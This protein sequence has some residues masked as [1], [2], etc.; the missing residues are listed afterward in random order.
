MYSAYL[1][2]AISENCYIIADPQFGSQL[3]YSLLPSRRMFGSITC[4]HESMVDNWNSVV[5]DDDTIL[6]L[7]DFTQNKKH[8]GQSLE[9]VEKFSRL[10][11][12]KKI[13]IRGNHDVEP[14][15]FYYDYG[16]K[17]VVEYPVIMTQGETRWLN[18][19]SVSAA[20]IIKD[21]AGL[22]IMFSHFAIF[23]SEQQD[24]RYLLEKAY[25]RE[26]FEEHRCDVNIH[27]HTHDRLVKSRDCLS[28]C[29]EKNYFTPTLLKDFL[30]INGR[31]RDSEL[32]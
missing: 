8:R 1:D 4:L 5:D 32:A 26:L 20:C 13:L 24:S 14:T 9:L 29:V 7:G 30:I 15:Q 28:A 31:S 25:L 27:G 6:C 2:D 23:E 17:L 10:L 11:K 18:V 19:P 3:V 21:I 22:R 12:G 16:W